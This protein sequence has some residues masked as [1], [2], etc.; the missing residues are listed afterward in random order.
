MKQ[1]ITFI[2]LSFS[3]SFV[4]QA[5]S[6][7]LPSDE[8]EADNKNSIGA[9][10]NVRRSDWSK[11][12]R[13]PVATKKAKYNIAVFTPMFLDSVDIADRLTRIPDFM[14]PGLDFYQGVEIAADTLR[15]K[16]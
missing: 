8:L 11:F 6:V 12:Y 2:L 1:I 3:V 9:R 7:V 14:K 5:Q 13:Y 15:R 10:D 4:A 16:G